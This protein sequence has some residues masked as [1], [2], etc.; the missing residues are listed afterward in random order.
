MEQQHCPNNLDGQEHLYDISQPVGK[1]VELTCKCGKFQ[2]Y[3]D[4][5]EFRVRLKEQNALRS[6]GQDSSG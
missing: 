2:I 1:N 5:Q 6:D 4:G 3:F